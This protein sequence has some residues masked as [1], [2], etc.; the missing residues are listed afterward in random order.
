MASH[1]FVFQLF[2]ACYITPVSHSMVA[3]TA[4]DLPIIDKPAGDDAVKSR[5][6]EILNPFKS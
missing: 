3:E 5:V 2:T 6:L 1:S 4:H